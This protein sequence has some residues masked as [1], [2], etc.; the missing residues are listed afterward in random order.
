MFFPKLKLSDKAT[1]DK[2]SLRE[3]F[4]SLIDEENNSVPDFP[5]E[6]EAWAPESRNRG[7]F[8]KKRAAAEEQPSSSS[9]DQ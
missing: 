6:D 2:S 4:K 9:G 3:S 1:K 7:L 5:Y 8:H